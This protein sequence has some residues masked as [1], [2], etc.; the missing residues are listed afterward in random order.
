MEPNCRQVTY[1]QIARLFLPLGATPVLIAVSHTM[2]S[3]TL[4]RL[5]EPELNLAAFAVL[6][7]L[8]NAIKAPTNATRQMVVALVDGKESYRKVT[9][10]LRI[11][12][13]GF[14]AALLL[15]ALTPLG[16]RALR[17]AGLSD[18]AELSL[19]SEALLFVVL[20][21]A[22]EMFR[23]LVHGLALGHRGAAMFPVGLG[24]RT[25]AIA[26][27]LG[28]FLWTGAL[29]GVLVGAIAWTSGIAVEG[30]FLAVYLIRRFGSLARV[31]HTIPRKADR[32]VSY[33]V[34]VRFF[35][36]MA[37]M[38]W[39]AGFLHPLVQSGVGGSDAPT[40]SLAAYGVAQGLLTL[41]AGG[42][43][44]IHQCTLA[45]VRDERDP[46]W[47]RVRIFSLGTGLAL[48]SVTLF[49]ALG[50]AGRWV[51]M[52]LMGIPE[53]VGKIALQ[54]LAVFS[55]QPLVAAWREAYWGMLM[56]QRRTSIIGLAKTANLAAVAAAVL[57]VFGPASALLG[58]NA[59]V[60]GAGVFCLGEAV[61]S[62]VIWR[63]SKHAAAR[64]RD[65][66]GSA[67]A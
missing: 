2:S 24:V 36:P 17:A 12:G 41:L 19:A 64:R 33:A 45:F 18:P 26:L 15:L 8:T 4:A 47:R 38:L 42:A 59:A 62:T 48:A 21:P 7:A 60:I 56:L 30:G 40:L 32:P 10:F 63:H 54:T 65:V 66:T 6:Q 16:E 53:T 44:M 3:A 11:V 51:V 43:S 31:A 52:G 46:N 28:T 9:T 20:L 13:S 67:A 29:P 23:N 37:V 49:I 1:G 58:L 27:M 25:V 57:T 35:A 39:I 34:I 61:E 14:V 5:P 22:V 55:I 50:P